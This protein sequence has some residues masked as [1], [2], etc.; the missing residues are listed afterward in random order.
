V[1]YVLILL[2]AG[3]LVAVGPAEAACS[4]DIRARMIKND[5]PQEKIDAVCGEPTGDSATAGGAAPGGRSASGS[6]VIEVNINNTN[7][8]VDDGGGLP[9]RELQEQGVI[10]PLSRIREKAHDLFEGSRMV[11]ADLQVRDGILVYVVD[12]IDD[13][14]Y[15][16]AVFDAG[17]GEALSLAKDG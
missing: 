14:V 9:V 12:L 13:G 3:Y 11:E 7:V 8:N 16:E 6:G 10:L 15:R 17:N 5:I 4:T 1:R 2:G